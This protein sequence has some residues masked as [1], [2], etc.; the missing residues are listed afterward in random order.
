MATGGAG[1]GTVASDAE[2]AAVMNEFLD[3]VYPENPEE[4]EH[5][6]THIPEN[7]ELTDKL[8][9]L[10]TPETV[11]KTFLINSKRI[12]PR[13]YIPIVVA[14]VH[15]PKFAKKLILE[16][17]AEILLENVPTLGEYIQTPLKALVETYHMMLED[18]HFP[19]NRDDIIAAIAAGY[20][21]A[22]DTAAVDAALNAA[23]EESYF[24]PEEIAKFRLKF[25]PALKNAI[26][27]A[28]WYRRKHLLPVYAERLSGGA[29][30]RRQTRRHRSRRHRNKSRKHSRK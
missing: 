5:G 7:K 14:A 18:E 16:L 20:A 15:D 12:G 25:M 29:R 11:N 30:R 19:G 8:F 9:K 26:R 10:L 6:Y 2:I 23:F 22:K 21:T 4:D 28:A 13:Q 1:T 17:G 24:T 3:H 27:E